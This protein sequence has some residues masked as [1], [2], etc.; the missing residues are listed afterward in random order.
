MPAA[1]CDDT[2]R[3]TAAWART[4]GVDDA[5]LQDSLARTSTVFCDCEVLL[6]VDAD[7]FF[8]PTGEHPS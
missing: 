6:N 8:E 3:L 1:G 2:F 7:D 4:Q 5:E